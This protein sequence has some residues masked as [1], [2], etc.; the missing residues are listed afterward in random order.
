MNWLKRNF[1]RIGLPALV[2]IF[3]A[4]L[5]AWAAQ[6][7]YLGTVFI[8]DST[9]PSQQLVVGSNGAASVQFASGGAGAYSVIISATITR[10]NNT[11]T[12]TAN[13]AW[14]DATSG[15]TAVSIAGIC[16]STG[17]QILVPEI[18]IYSS[19]NQTTKLQG[20]LWLFTTTVGTPVNDNATF[21]IAAADYA[22]LTGNVQGFPFT[23]VSNQA[24]GAANAGIS[25]TGTAYH[26]ACAGGS[27]NM[28]A[29][30]QVV[31]AY[32]PLANEILTMKIH[33]LAAN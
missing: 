5:I 24:S 8:A 6:T 4:T 29:M 30:V 14:A 19:A 15:A 20:V 11:T 7:N 33:A 17:G 12:Y 23:M 10:P 28:R 3:V 26:A 16:R 13:T 22:N 21:N 2:S 1:A 27:Q 9:T 31:N 18:D 25:L 32:V